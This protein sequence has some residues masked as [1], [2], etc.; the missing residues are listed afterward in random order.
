MHMIC[1]SMP[2][3]ASTEF[4]EFLYILC[5][6]NNYRIPF[7]RPLCWHMRH[8]HMGDSVRS[9]EAKMG[10]KK[11]MHIL[12][13]ISSVSSPQNAPKSITA[14]ASPQTPL[15]SLQRFPQTPS[16]VWKGLLL[17]PLLQTGGERIYAAG[18]RNHRAS[19][20]AKRIIS[21][22]LSVIVIMQM[23]PAECAWLG[24]WRSTC[25]AHSMTEF[26]FTSKWNHLLK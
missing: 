26:Y 6:K 2:I 8:M 19:T 22:I 7:R 4:T 18:A 9:V 17:R 20:G 10:I 25:S 24:T 1:P 21:H 11:K 12:D 5:R 13:V 16:W 23:S 3:P 15:G 14:G